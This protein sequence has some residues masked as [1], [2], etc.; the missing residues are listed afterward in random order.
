MHHYSDHILPGKERQQ[1]VRYFLK[2]KKKKKAM[3]KGKRKRV[4]C[5]PL[6]VKNLCI[7]PVAQDSKL[8]ELLKS[9]TSQ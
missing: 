2:L 6:A 5:K 4:S 3:N 8:N 1:F 9:L 7:N